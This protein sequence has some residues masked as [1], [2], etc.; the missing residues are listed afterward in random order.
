M[1]QRY[2]IILNH[3][4]KSNIPETEYLVLHGPEGRFVHTHNRF[5]LSQKP[6]SVHS[7]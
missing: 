7:K 5:Q 3:K 2:I 1:W 6:D 4:I